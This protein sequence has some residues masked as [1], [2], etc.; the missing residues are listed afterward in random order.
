MD[1]KLAINMWKALSEHIKNSDTIRR[2][3]EKFD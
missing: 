2:K 3:I 1:T